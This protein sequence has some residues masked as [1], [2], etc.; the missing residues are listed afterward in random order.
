[1][2]DSDKTFLQTGRN[3]RIRT[4]DL[5]A[6]NALLYQTELHSVKRSAQQRQRRVIDPK[7]AG[8]MG[9]EPIYASSTEK[10]SATDP[11]AHYFSMP[12]MAD[13]QGFEPQI[14]AS[15]ADVLPLHYTPKNLA[16]AQGIEPQT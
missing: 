12:K 10:W 6:P 9:I 4:S 16:G 7:M 2:V 15:K 14:P 11:T 5:G 13:V 3:A 8:C 1:M